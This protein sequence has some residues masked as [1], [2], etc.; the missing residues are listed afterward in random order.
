MVT[1]GTD[2]YKEPGV[3]GIPTYGAVELEGLKNTRIFDPKTNS[4]SPVRRDALRPLVPDD[5]S[6]LP[7]GTHVHGQRGDQADQAGLRGPTAGLGHQRQADRELRPEDRHLDREPGQCEQVA[8]PV[9]AAAPAARRQDVLRRGRADV[10]PVRP[11]LRR[12]AVELRHRLRPEDPEV[13]RQGPAQRGGPSA[14]IPRVRVLG[15][16]AARARSRRHVLP[17]SV[18]VRG[19]GARCQ[20]RHLP[21]DELHHA[22]HDR[23]GAQRQAGLEDDREPERAAVVRHRHGAADRPGV[24][25]RR[26]EP[27]RGRAAGH[28]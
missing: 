14:G 20:P 21:G 27:R 18:P 7:D 2:Y 3:P 4:W 17:G 23:H 19:R 11:V 28:R 1:G 26:R 13:D 24:P 10:Q 16:A 6:P 25:L 15:D 9:P 5:W 8:A 22:E 12:G